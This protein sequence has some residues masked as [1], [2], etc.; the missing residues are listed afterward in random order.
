M[1]EPTLDPPN[2]QLVILKVVKPLF[3]G[4]ETGASSALASAERRGKRCR[5]E[6]GINPLC[7]GV[8]LLGDENVWN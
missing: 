1:N 7:T 4:P 8:P 3:C 6:K 2:S 5:E